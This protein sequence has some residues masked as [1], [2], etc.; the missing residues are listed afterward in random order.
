MP[1]DTAVQ[2]WWQSDP[3]DEQLEILRDL[4]EPS[5]RHINRAFFA[6]LVPDFGV[7]IPPFRVLTEA[8]QFLL[9]AMK[10]SA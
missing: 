4:I 2:V 6:I 3:T 5:Y 8:T 9:C 7:A 1:F 10:V